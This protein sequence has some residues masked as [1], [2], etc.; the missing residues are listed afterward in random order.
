LA[1]PKPTGSQLSRRSAST[2]TPAQERPSARLDSLFKVNGFAILSWQNVFIVVWTIPS[3]LELVEQLSRHSAQFHIDHPAG[4]SV[5]HIIA[6][7][8]P[9]PEPEVRER[10]SKLLGKNPKTLA[11]VGVVLEGRGFWASAIRSFLLGLRIVSPRSVQ[12]QAFSTTREVATWMPDPH[13]ARTGVRIG[14]G[15]FERALDDARASVEH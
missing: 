3:S 10:F 8:P 7:G 15:Q 4:V 1:A 9:L 2:D 12:M 11:C 14:A 5:V 13:A 6:K